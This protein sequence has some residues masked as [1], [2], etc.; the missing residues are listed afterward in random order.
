ML[1]KRPFVSQ[2]VGEN[3]CVW[4]FSTTPLVI[5]PGWPGAYAHVQGALADG[6]GVAGDG[7]CDSAVVYR[8]LVVMRLS[9][10]PVVAFGFGDAA[11][12]Q[13]Q[14]YAICCSK[15]TLSGKGT[16][17]GPCRIVSTSTMPWFWARCAQSRTPRTINT[18]ASPL[19]TPTAVEPCMCAWYQNVPAG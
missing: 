8:P 11:G 2:I 15:N 7:S 4:K 3:S 6:G 1:V 13:K 16:L 18:P 5:V 9:Y 17:S 14:P 12:C 19:D 10:G